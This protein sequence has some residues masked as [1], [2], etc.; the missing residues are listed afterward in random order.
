MRFLADLFFFIFL[1]YPAKHHF[2]KLLKS[3][4]L[5]ITQ[6]KWNKIR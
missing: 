4:K 5:F 6:R 3:N 2:H 1:I